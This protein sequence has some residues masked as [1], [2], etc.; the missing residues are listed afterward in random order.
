MVVRI[1]RSAL[2]QMMDW[3]E[4]SPAAEVCGLLLGAP[5]RISTAVPALNVA[6]DPARRFE[7]D[8]AVLIAAH[9][10]ARAGGPAVIGSWHSHPS[11]SAEPSAC[12]AALA[13]ADGSLWLILAP[14]HWAIW[15]AGT[16]GLHGRF[17]RERV[18]V[19]EDASD[20]PLASLLP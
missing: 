18:E 15:R 20:V 4:R 3:A 6:D 5:D 10:G 13:A 11:G 1:S 17:G 2:A 7:I 9:R 16:K 8:P 14:P 19:G 12:D